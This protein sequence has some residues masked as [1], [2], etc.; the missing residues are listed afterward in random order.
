MKKKFIY[1][2]AIIM[3]VGLVTGCGKELKKGEKVVAKV[4][5]YKVTADDL[6]NEM[7]DKYAIKILIDKID[8]ELMDTKFKTDDKETQN[9]DDQIKQIKLSYS[10]KDDD[11]LKSVI[12]DIYGLDS[13]KELRDMLSLQYKRDL[14]IKDYVAN[15]VVTSEEV[16]EYY[17]KK[18]IGEVEVKHILIRPDS[19]ENDNEDVKEQKENEAKQKAQDIIKKLD[20]GEKFETLAKKYSDDKASASKGGKIGNFTSTDNLEDSIVQALASLK[21]GNYTKEPVKTSYGYEVILKVN[22][23]DKKTKEDLEKDIRNTIAEDK[24]NSDT[25]TSAYYK[26][27]RDFRESS[28]L[29]FSDSS[30]EKLYNKYMDSLINTDNN[31]NN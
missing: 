6:Y 10:V 28:G 14:A 5:D 7:K 1:G 13:E 15:K 3:T 16:T 4:S 30:I 27:L 11:Q 17:D 26:R 22:E 20:N 29:K 25:S 19:S 2:M 9:I 18:I 23:K 8:H 24:I 12:K 31:N 21:K